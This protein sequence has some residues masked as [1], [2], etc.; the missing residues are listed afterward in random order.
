MFIDGF[1][2]DIDSIWELLL[3]PYKM[4]PIVGVTEIPDPNEYVGRR[5]I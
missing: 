1:N 5:D 4:L 2:S 3:G